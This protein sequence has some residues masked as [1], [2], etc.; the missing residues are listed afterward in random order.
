VTTFRCSV[1]A[2]LAGDPLEATAPP[3]DRWLLV[4]HAGP[5]GRHAITESKVHPAAAAAFVA[6]TTS[7]CAR[8]ALI[9]R[10]GAVHRARKT[11]RW[12]LVDARLGHE[13]V[14]TGVYTDEAQLVDVMADP[15]SGEPSA[16]PVYL[17][18][19]HGKHDT[20]CA[21]RGRPVAEALARAF[22][23]RTWECTHVGGDRFAANVVLLPHG[24]YYGQVTPR[25]AV[26]LAKQHEAG[27]LDVERLRGR[28]SLPAPV[29]A[30][31]HHAR[32]ASGE[33]AIDGYPPLAVEPVGRQ[34]WRVR[35]AGPDGATVVVTVQAAIRETDRPLTCTG[36]VPD[37]F[38]IFELVDLHR[39]DDDHVPRT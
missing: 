33:T 19:T 11:G 21:L 26:D 3:A 10:P 31:Q 38:R 5:W 35:L 9:R 34:R 30:A 36:R 16:E 37:R 27:T 18:C 8:V 4:E 12:Y 28:S 39:A 13:S 6:W 2:E 15:A 25:E 14:R 7:N 32:L 20:C 23:Q 24:L 29:Q 1:A 22:P 17:V